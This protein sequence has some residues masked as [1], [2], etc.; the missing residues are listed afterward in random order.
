MTLSA[1]LSCLSGSSTLIWAEALKN[2][3]THIKKCLNGLAPVIRTGIE[4]PGMITISSSFK[5]S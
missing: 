4:A 3:I 5:E 2:L 1:R